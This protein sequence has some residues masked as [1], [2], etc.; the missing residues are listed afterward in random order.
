MNIKTPIVPKLPHREKIDNILETYRTASADRFRSASK[1][2]GHQ[3]RG[4]HG[5]TSAHIDGMIAGKPGHVGQGV[6]THAVLAVPH[7][8][9]S[10]RHCNVRHAMNGAARVTAI[11]RA[12]NDFVVLEIS[13][14]VC[15]LRSN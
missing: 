1:S 3:A 10:R 5:A 2:S 7:S 9:Q 6:G 13:A 4:K 11:F 15:D 8:P 12:E 14:A